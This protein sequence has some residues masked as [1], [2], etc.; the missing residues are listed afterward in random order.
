[1]GKTC[2]SKHSALTGAGKHHTG[3]IHTFKN[4]GTPLSVWHILW[5]SRILFHP[6]ALSFFI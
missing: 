2:I 1:M 4:K 3:T 5:Y 6:R